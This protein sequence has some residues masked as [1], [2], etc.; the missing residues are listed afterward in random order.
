MKSKHKDASK[1][2]A[3]ESRRSAGGIA[4]A[5]SLTPE[6]RS[7]IAREAAQRRWGVD[8][9][10]AIAGSA[11][12]PLTIGGID[13]EC[14]VLEDGTR[15]IT[16]ASFMKAMGRTRAH[17]V[18]DE[19]LPPFLRAQSLRPYVTDEIIE[20]S[21][22]VLFT[23]P[24]GG[25]A[26]GYRAELLPDVCELYL[27]AREEKKLPPNQL[28][29]ARQAEILIRG[30][31]QVG[32]IALVDEA[33]GYQEVRARDALIKILEAYVD[34][35]LQAWVRTFP[36]DYYQQIFRLRGLDYPRDTVKRPPYFGH[37][38]ND[39]IY[40]RIAPGVLEELKRVQRKGSTG[41]PKDK[42]FQ[43]LT[44]NKGYPQLREHLGSVVTMMKMSPDWETFMKQ[45]DQIHP[46]F[47]ETIPLDFDEIMHGRG[48]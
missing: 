37:I 47:N 30:L 21:R 11:D 32:I 36:D 15:V 39:I 42:L 34:K 48:L 16:Q 5:K 33:T 8:A 12:R 35:E 9:L 22:P 14:Y 17:G 7:A 43:R 28:H 31:A 6:Q 38:T 18:A 46:R 19:T 44:T 10:P 45:L 41:K 23:L 40:K 29:V 2:Q 1:D 26:Y 27:R 13:I 3:D 25:R 20:A 4:R 24:R